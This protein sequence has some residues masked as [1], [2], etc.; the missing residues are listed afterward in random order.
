[1]TQTE[2][3]IVEIL[4]HNKKMKETNKILLQTLVKAAIPLEVL[5]GQ[6]S[7]KP[8]AELTLEFQEDIAITTQTVRTIVQLYTLK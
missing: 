8:Y 7:M 2:N 3:D 4:E 1:M 5:A 6:I